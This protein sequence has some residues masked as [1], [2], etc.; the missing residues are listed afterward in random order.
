M[1]YVMSL[2]RADVRA[3]HRPASTFKEKCM[4]TTTEKNWTR[5]HPNGMVWAYPGV[6]NYYKQLQGVGLW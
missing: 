2:L 3:R 1:H 5:T 6:E 4:M